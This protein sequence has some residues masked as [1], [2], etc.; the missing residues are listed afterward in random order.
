MSISIRHGGSCRFS[1]VGWLDSV[2]DQA[3]SEGLQGEKTQLMSLLGVKRTW[4]VA[5]NMSAFDPK[6]TCA[7]LNERKRNSYDGLCASAAKASQARYC[8]GPYAHS[9]GH[10][11]RIRNSCL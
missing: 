7:S 10:S 2:Q 1:Y 6:R 3:T 11:L 9:L 4:A 5:P 8:G